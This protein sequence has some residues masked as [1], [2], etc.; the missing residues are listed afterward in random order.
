MKIVQI[1]YSGLG[2]HSGVVFPLIS[3]DSSRN[4]WAI[5]FVGSSKLLTNF[6]DQCNLLKIQY[7][8]FLFYSGFPFFAWIK[9]FFWLYKIRPDG[10]ICHNT[11]F[12]LPC[13]AYSLL[14][15]ASLIAV[16]HTNN[17]L[18]RK[19]DWFFSLFALVIANK[20]VLLTES[21][22]S[23]L[24]N[25]FK[26]FNHKKKYQVIPNGVDIKKFPLIK[27]DNNKQH[28]KPI[29]TLGMAARFTDTKRQDLLLNAIKRVHESHYGKINLQ[30]K[31]AGDGPELDRIRSLAKQLE[32][33]SIV[34]FEGLIEESKLPDWYKNINLYIH[35]TDGET[36]SISILQAMSAGL[37]ILA[38]DVDGI[39]NLLYQ[40]DRFGSCVANDEGS[41]AKEIIHIYSN[42]KQSL[43]TGLKARAKVE[44][45]Y[46][47]Y[48]MLQ[49]Y[50]S[51]L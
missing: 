42:Y 27:F 12:I 16:E 36:L 45:D 44:R 18:K 34:S 25:V 1:C 47:S 43:N 3:A 33:S 46:S 7:K 14:S 8:N 13:K 26:Y 5:G 50:L 4:E 35:A 11:S 30:L 19:R 37:P 28:A 41:F 21:Y 48:G 51:L 17:Q 38:S 9:L 2:G 6:V 29:F 32:I 49:S 40:E 10:I 31:L 15:G 20:V 24:E 23:E 22:K 39:S